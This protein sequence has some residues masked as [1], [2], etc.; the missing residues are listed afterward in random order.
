MHVNVAENINEAG[1]SD[2]I[3]DSDEPM[4][5]VFVDRC[6]PR[7]AAIP[8]DKRC[9]DMGMI[10]RSPKEID[11]QLHLLFSD[12]ERYVALKSDEISKD[13]RDSQAY[14]GRYQGWL[15]LG[16]LERALADISASIALEEQPISYLCRGEVLCRLGRYETALEDFNKGEQL[17]PAGWPDLW[18][19]LH[20]ADCHSRLGHEAEALTACAKL[21]D[22][23]WMPGLDGTP[24]GSKQEVIAEV[25]RRLAAFRERPKDEPM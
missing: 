16:N 3:A 2:D 25:R 19:P 18:G 17:D 4:S 9:K 13:S 15:R 5:N 12:P 8:S 10:N 24:A 14:F 22:D 6:P 21:K 7:V 11:A 20:Q 1:Y 23:H